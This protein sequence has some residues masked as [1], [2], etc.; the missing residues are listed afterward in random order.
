M[1]ELEALRT[2]FLYVPVEG[3]AEQEVT[4]AGRL[5]RHDAGVRTR[6]PTTTPAVLADAIVAHLGEKVSYPPVVADGAHPAAARVLERGGARRYARDPRAA[7][8]WCMNTLRTQAAIPGRAALAAV[9]LAAVLA[10]PACSARI[11]FSP[12]ATA[13]VTVS[14]SVEGDLLVVRVPAS[15]PSAGIDVRVGDGSAVHIPPG[16]YPPPGQ[17]RI[18]RPGVPP[19]QQEA[20]G[21]CDDLERRVPPNA[22]LVIG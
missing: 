17:C 6:V 7:R 18:W 5:A 21:D 10:L 20:P 16:H 13:Q 9:V 3:H 8:Q 14:A 11:D 15:R 2:P 1:L 19:G 4:V 12:G 22:V